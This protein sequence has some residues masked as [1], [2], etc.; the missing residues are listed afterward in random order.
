MPAGNTANWPFLA[1]T[2]SGK[3]RAQPLSSCRRNLNPLKAPPPVA[4]FSAPSAEPEA[5]GGL[6]LWSPLGIPG[7]ACT[8]GER[9]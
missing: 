3:A 2:S 4:Q 5:A 7:A 6:K 8:C 1:M 9:L